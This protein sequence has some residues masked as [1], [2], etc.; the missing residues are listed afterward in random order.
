MV[1]TL[2]KKP[3]HIKE[4][5]VD[6]KDGLGGGGGGGGGGGDLNVKLTLSRD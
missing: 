5:Y 2:L 6:V 4:V 1:V 3:G